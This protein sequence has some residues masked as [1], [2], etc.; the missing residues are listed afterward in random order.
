MQ[1]SMVETHKTKNRTTVRSSHPTPEYLTMDLL[2]CNVSLR[3]NHNGWVPWLSMMRQRGL[4][5]TVS[6]RDSRPKIFGLNWAHHWSRILLKQGDLAL[7]S[8]GIIL[9]VW[10]SGLPLSNGAGDGQ[11]RGN[12]WIFP[13]QW[14]HITPKQLWSAFLFRNCSLIQYYIQ[15][16]CSGTWS[17]YKLYRIPWQINWENSKEM[18]KWVSL[19]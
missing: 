4:E 13:F 7:E 2:L 14:N 3:D 17:M 11:Y 6:P 15:I 8:D 1:I 18:G 12:P 5:L 10:D 16:T 9:G 19:V